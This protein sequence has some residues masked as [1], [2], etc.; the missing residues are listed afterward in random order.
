[1]LSDI[2]KS[3]KWALAKIGGLL[4][5][6]VV[7]GFPPGIVPD[8][9]LRVE[10]GRV[11][12]H[13]KDFQTMAL[14]FEPGPNFGM[15]MIRCFVLDKVNAVAAPVIGRQDDLLDKGQIGDVFEI[16][17]LVPV[18]ELSALQTDSAEDLLCVA[19]STCGYFRPTVQGCPRLMQGG[20][21]A[22]GGLV[23]INNY[24]AFVT[25][26]LLN[27]DKCNES[28]Y[29]A[30]WDRLVPDGWS[31][32]ARSTPGDEGVFARGL[33]GSRQRTRHV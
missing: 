27:W 10:F 15:S 31:A 22:K 9:L 33:D 12:G 18:G 11:F 7:G 23:H 26:V 21:L 4:K 13:R 17:G 19:F 29:S 14:L 1:M 6:S 28:T 2:V 24:G 8:S 32:V 20:A 25:G 30:L 16:L 5:E 3:F